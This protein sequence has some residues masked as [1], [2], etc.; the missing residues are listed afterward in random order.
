MVFKFLRRIKAEVLMYAAAIG[1][2]KAT[3]LGYDRVLTPLIGT[4]FSISEHQK[5]KPEFSLSMLESIENS[6]NSCLYNLKHNPEI[7]S[8]SSKRIPISEMPMQFPDKK[9]SDFYK[10]N[11]EVLKSYYKSSKR[12]VTLESDILRQGD[13][14]YSTVGSTLPVNANLSGIRKSIFSSE[15]IRVMR[16]LILRVCISCWRMEART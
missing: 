16:S 4:V 9:D 5:L 3:F 11:L 8:K 6:V 2:L 13:N 12:V 1:A 10:I 15:I 7:D 14:S